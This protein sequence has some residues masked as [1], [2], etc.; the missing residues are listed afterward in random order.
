[1]ICSLNKVE[2]FRKKYDAPES[3]S[4]SPTLYT[5]IDSCH[6]AGNCCR[7]PFDLI[8]TSFDYRRIVEYN[9]DSARFLFGESSAN[10]FLRS[11]DDLLKTLEKAIVRINIDGK[12]IR[13]DLYIKRNR[14]LSQMSGNYSCPYLVMSKD[15][16]FCGVHPFKPLH[17]WY[18]HMT[19]NVLERENSPSTVA[20]GRRQYG[21]NHKFG[22]PV[23]FT[24]PNEE[25]GD[26]VDQSFDYLKEQ[27]KSDVDKLKW[28]S[29]SAI[30]LGI[31]KEDNFACQISS[32]FEENRSQIKY[33]LER[34]AYEQII[35]WKKNSNSLF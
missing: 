34:K 20:I 22:C 4:I 28:T 25:T 9:H 12:E 23:L 5:R 19:V 32:V 21:R 30:S 10:S 33:N 14:A 31:T 2:V 18:P 13:S 6:G 29:D 27:F 16:Y 17:C 8:Y 35:L 7:V 15:R 1:V 11:R 26:I 24:S 3:I